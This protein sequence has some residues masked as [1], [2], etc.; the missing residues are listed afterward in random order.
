[1]T[2]GDRVAVLK[3]GLLQQCDTPLKLYERPA[4]VF[5]AGLRVA[6]LTSRHDPPPSFEMFRNS[7]AGRDDRTSPTTRQE[8]VSKPNVA[9]TSHQGPCKHCL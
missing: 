2:M 7:F 4:N 9:E 6:G 3:D 1:M 5:V 8:L